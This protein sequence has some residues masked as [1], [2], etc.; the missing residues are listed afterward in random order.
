MLA[1]PA[2]PFV[3]D[4]VGA[5]RLIKLMAVTALDLSALPESSEGDDQLPTVAADATLRE[6]MIALLNAPAGRIRVL[7]AQGSST[8]T[9]NDV[10]DLIAGHRAPTSPAPRT[11]RGRP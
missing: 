10:V 8:L 6:A 2:T 9:I 11:Q 1:H 4:F 7:S 3:A 5:D